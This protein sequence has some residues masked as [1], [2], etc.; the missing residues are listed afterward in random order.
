[1]GFDRDPNEI[2]RI[3][4]AVAGAAPDIVYVG[5]TTPMQDA[6]IGR[7]RERLPRSW[8][9]G[10]G[11]SFSLLS[12]E[13]RR[14]PPWLQ[15]A[16]LEWLHRMIQEPRRLTPRYARSIPL[17]IALLARALAQRVLRPTRGD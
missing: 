14:A 3:V 15:R 5:L 6:L 8:E 4:D 7:L 16:G 17:A 1:M 13:V 10:V 2:G 11:I 12:G 9:V